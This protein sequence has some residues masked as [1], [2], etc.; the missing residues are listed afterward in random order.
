MGVAVPLDPSAFSPVTCACGLEGMLGCSSFCFLLDAEA[1]TL[2]Y[3]FLCPPLR[4]FPNGL[5]RRAEGTP[6][7]HILF[8]MKW[9]RVKLR[10]HFDRLFDVGVA[11]PLDPSAFSPVTFACGLEG[12]LGCSSCCFLLDAEAAGSD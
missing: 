12:M 6:N 9:L 10:F 3:I 1:A 2:I 11:V 5:T 7:S 8:W 4:R